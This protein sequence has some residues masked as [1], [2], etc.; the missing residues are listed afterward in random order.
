MNVLKIILLYLLFVNLLGYFLM[1]IDKL[2]AKRQSFRI[3]ES[4]L[5]LTAII[6]GSIGTILGMYSF[7]H[8]TRHPF[9]VYGLPAIF[10]I[11]LILILWFHYYSPFTFK[12]M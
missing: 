8:K 2:K 5:F 4:T 6:G 9:F 12:I 11:Q 1:G 7:R 3:P 10:L